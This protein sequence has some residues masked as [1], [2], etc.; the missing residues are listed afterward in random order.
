LLEMNVVHFFSSGR[1]FCVDLSAWIT[2]WDRER[3][4]DARV[5]GAA[6][7]GRGLWRAGDF[8][9]LLREDVSFVNE[10]E[11]ERTNGSFRICDRGCRNGERHCIRKCQNIVT[12]EK[13]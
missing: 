7:F 12:M 2:D 8:Y 1:V 4:P 9:G 3:I 11:R 6:R 10:R 5:Q 13:G